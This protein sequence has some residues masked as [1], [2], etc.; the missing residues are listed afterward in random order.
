MNRK[1]SLSLC[2]IIVIGVI[3]LAPPG[4][5][6]KDKGL[7]RTQGLINPGGNLKA[8]Y[9][10]VNEMRIYLDPSTQIMDHRGKTVPATDLKA[11]KWVY[12]EVDTGSP[13]KM[14]AR[15]IYL[16]PRYIGP[17]EKKQFAFMK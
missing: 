8:G 10:L 9:L 6:G 4:V 14:R 5:F 17:A 1:K 7:F 16:L 11:K 13:R 2:V 15:N 12:L 3:L